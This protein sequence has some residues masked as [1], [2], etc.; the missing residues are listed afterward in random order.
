MKCNI[1]GRED[2]VIRPGEIETALHS[3][4]AHVDCQGHGQYRSVTR[5]EL[6]GEL[7]WDRVISVD[8]GSQ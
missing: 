5:D 1:C 6:H 2:A 4:R 3:H 7:T 8:E